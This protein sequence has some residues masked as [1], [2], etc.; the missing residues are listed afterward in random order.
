MSLVTAAHLVC[1]DTTTSAIMKWVAKLR[2][3]G[4]NYRHAGRETVTLVDAFGF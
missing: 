1:N 4:F 3:G 2:G